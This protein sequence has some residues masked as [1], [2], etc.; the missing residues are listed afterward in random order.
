MKDLN[1]RNVKGVFFDFDGTILNS[2]SSQ[3]KAYQATFRRFKIQLTKSEFLRNYSP[4]WLKTY[5]A[6]GLPGEC[7][8][9][10]DRLWLQEIVRF[11]SRFFPRAKTMLIN[12]RKS[13]RLGL[14]IRI[15]ATGSS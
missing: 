7:W 9:E 8:Q 11:P 4:N 6:F 14:D 3:F 15:K 13:Y 2:F 12:L 10:A 5:E 1:T